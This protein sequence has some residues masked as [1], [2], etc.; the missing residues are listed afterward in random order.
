VSGENAKLQK[1][2]GK[3]APNQKTAQTISFRADRRGNFLGIW[4]LFF[5]IS[6]G[7]DLMNSPRAASMELAAARCERYGETQNLRILKSLCSVRLRALCVNPT[8]TFTDVGLV[9]P[10]VLPPRSFG[11]DRG[12]HNPGRRRPPELTGFRTSALDRHRRRLLLLVKG[13]G[14]K[15]GVTR[16]VRSPSTLPRRGIR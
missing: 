15:T 12:S 3:Q 7:R 4:R 10:R 13:Q 8:I 6:R 16:V 9:R 14:P 11:T 1:P 5:G 2:T